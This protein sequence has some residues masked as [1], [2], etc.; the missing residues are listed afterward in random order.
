VNKQ[1]ITFIVNPVSGTGNQN[2]LESAIKNHLDLLR[3]DYILNYTEAKEHATEL[4]AKALL[5][6]FMVIAVGGDG[7]IN[8]VAKALINTSIPLG[9]IPCGSGNGLST[10]YDI[11]TKIHDAVKLINNGKILNTD[12]ALINGI[13]YLSTAGIGFDAHIA[14]KFNQL[15]K[16]GFSSYA[17]LVLTEWI[18]FKP[19]HFIFSVDGKKFER[20]A[21]LMTIA[22]CSQYG[23]NAFIAPEAKTDDGKLNITLVKPF[24]FWAIPGLLRRLF[25]KKLH[26]SPFV[27]TFTGHEI[28]VE[29][30]AESAHYD[31]EY[32]LSGKQLKFKNV[33]G[34]LKILVPEGNDG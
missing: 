11:P 25:N 7:T 34:S 16:R 3:F 22:N 5:D 15:K 12:T 13:P 27:E 33:P 32:W 4:A 23:N 30:T 28:E 1:K 20:S 29:Q 2:Q 14:Q 24:P 6:S 18:N 21:F 17:R 26:L 8:E 31:G 19:L 9:V 10:H